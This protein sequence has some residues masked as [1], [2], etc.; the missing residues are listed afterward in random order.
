M[1]SYLRR[2]YSAALHRN[3]GMPHTTST[4]PPRSEGRRTR[5]WRLVLGGLLLVLVLVAL[6]LLGHRRSNLADLAASRHAFE[7]EVAT[8]DPERSHPPRDA[9]T[10]EERLAKLR[11]ARQ[12]HG[13]GRA[14]VD[15]GRW[16]EVVALVVALEGL[17]TELRQEEPIL[18]DLMLSR[19]IGQF[20]LDLAAAVVEA[21]QATAA[22]LETIR[23]TLAREHDALGIDAAMAHECQLLLVASRQLPAEAG[24]GDRAYR[25]W[26]GT[27]ETASAIR[28]YH[29]LAEAMEQPIL[30]V[31]AHLRERSQPKPPAFRVVSS[32]LIPNLT[33]VPLDHRF[34][35]TGRRLLRLATTYR[36]RHLAGGESPDLEEPG[37][38]ALGLDGLSSEDLVDAVTGG[39]VNWDAAAVT[40]SFRGALEHRETLPVRLD[41]APPAV[42]LTLRLPVTATTGTGAPGV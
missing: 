40:V 35:L 19:A 1:Y 39:R 17:R 15:A 16:D 9:A 13:Q 36:L 30:D 6:L 31:S 21:P 18:T 24:L 28:L 42:P 12:L 37:P 7:Q 41:T 11:Q 20:G 34:E 32:I 5:R 4:H 33:Q 29:A 14:S 25:W 38:E 8:L 26:W 27:S 10:S 22:Q 23:S 2:E 3:L